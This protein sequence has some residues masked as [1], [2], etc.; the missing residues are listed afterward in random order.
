MIREVRRMR[1]KYYRERKTNKGLGSEESRERLR[2]MIG[3]VKREINKYKTDRWCSF[4]SALQ[5]QHDKRSTAFWSH[6]SRLYK[7]KTFTFSKLMKGTDTVSD[8]QEIAEELH[9]YY[10]E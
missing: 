4:L 9:G 7:P 5:E 6:L 8:Q 1:S 2:N 3:D 10:Q